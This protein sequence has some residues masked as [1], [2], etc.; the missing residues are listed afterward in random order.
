MRGA[1]SADKY[2][3]G[4]WYLGK[5]SP[6]ECERDVGGGGGHSSVFAKWDLLHGL[7]DKA[8]AGGELRGRMTKT[9][10]CDKLYIHHLSRARSCSFRQRLV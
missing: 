5:A 6:N 8:D 2:G 7:H 3:G 1:S 4:A 9:D 10:I